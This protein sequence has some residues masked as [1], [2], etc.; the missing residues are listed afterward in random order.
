MSVQW[1]WS[2]LDELRAALRALPADLTTDAGAIVRRHGDAAVRAIV[3]GYPE[4]TG[5]LKRGVTIRTLA[6]TGRFYAGVQVRSQAPHAL[7]YERGTKTRAYQGANRGVMPPAPTDAR[8]LGHILRERRDM[9]GDF[10]T[11]L[12]SREIGRAHV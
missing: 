2:G 7:I 1:S 10:R 6:G 4:V 11:L 9:Y 5:N 12:A 3:A 8:A